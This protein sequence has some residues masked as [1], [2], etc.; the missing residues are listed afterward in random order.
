MRSAVLNR[1][2]QL[3]DGAGTAYRA[4]IEQVTDTPRKEGG[5]L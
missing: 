4:I 5:P 1:L 2:R 3:I